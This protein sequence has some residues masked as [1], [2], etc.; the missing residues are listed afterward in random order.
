MG[1]TWYGSLYNLKKSSF[2]EEIRNKEENNY[3]FNM[4]WRCASLCHDII[5]FKYDG[6]DHYS[7]SSQDEVVLLDAGRYTGFSKLSARDSDYMTIEMESGS[8]TYKIVKVIEFDSD[9]K[10][11]TVILQDISNEKLFAFCK[12]ADMAILPR[13]KDKS[14]LEALKK[15]I[16]KISSKGYRTLCYSFKEL[17]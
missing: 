9:R 8:E 3:I 6:K 17:P 1:E 2:I 12:G 13:L 5:I 7:G 14:Q 11:M 4:F 15:E 16:S 10:M